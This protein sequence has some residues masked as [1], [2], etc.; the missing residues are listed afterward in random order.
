M[1]F[2]PPQRAPQAINT[3]KCT[4]KTALHIKEEREI[5]DA[6]HHKKAANE[7]ALPKKWSLR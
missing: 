6:P 7:L 2:A 5:E 1:L 3:R 4:E